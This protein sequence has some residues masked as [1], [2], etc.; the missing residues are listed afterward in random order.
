MFKHKLYFILFTVLFSGFF[1]VL[2]NKAFSQLTVT[3]GSALGLTPLGLI[4]QVL[5]GN[6]VTVSNGT[7]NG[8]AAIISSDMIGEFNA[9]GGATTQLG[10]SS[11]III[12]SGGASLA[13]GPNYSGSS[14]SASL[15]GSDPDLQSLVPYNVVFDKAVLEFDFVPIADTI[16]F[17]YVFGSEEFDEYCNSSYNDVFGFFVS[18]PG[19][20]GPFT[21][22]AI[23]IARM[24]NNPANYVTIN[25]ICN[26]GATYSWFN[27]SGVYYQYDRLTKVYT[28]W[29]LVQ[30]CQTYHL[31]IAVGDC[32]DSSFDSGVFIKANSFSAYGVTVSSSYSLPGAGDNAVEGCSDGYVTFRLS[33]P[34]SSAYTIPFTITGSAINGTDYTYIPNNIIVPA[35]QDSVRVVIHPLSDGLVEGTETVIFNVQTIVCGAGSSLSMN[36]ID[37]PPVTVNASNDT[38]ICGDPATLW[39][40]ATGG[41]PPYSYIWDNGAGNTASVVVNPAQTTT[42]SCT[43]TDLCAFSATE[44]VVIS[45][46]LTN[47]D[48][49][50]NDTICFGQTASLNATGGNSYLWSTGET[51]STISVSPSSTTTYYVTVFSTCTAMDS[52]TVVVNPLPVAVASSNPSTV[53]FGE[54]STICATGG[55][56]YFWTANPSDLTLTGQNTNACPVVSPGANTLYTVKVTDVNGCY[57]T[58]TVS[59]TVEAINPIINFSGI[60]LAGCEPLSVTFT[61]HSTQVASNARYFWE[62]G[63]GTFSYEKNPEG[64]YDAPGVYDVR[65]TITNPGNMKATVVLREYVTVYPKPTAILSTSPQNS[66]TI[67]DPVFRFYDESLGNPVQWLWDFG[68]GNIDTRQYTSHCYADRLPYYYYDFDLIQDTGTYLVTLGVITNHGCT[69]STSKYIHIEPAHD[70][71]IPNAFS[72][73]EDDKNNDFCINGFGVIEENYR[74]YIYNR[75]GELVYSTNKISGC[76]DGK[77]G[78]KPAETGIYA[79]IVEYMDVQHISHEA[80]GVIM[81]FR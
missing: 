30:P 58:D 9:T 11:G 79:Y 38:T 37:N 10:F 13:I 71:Y 6:G 72:P 31:K 39:V 61:D 42:Y 67:V 75:Q 50:P 80:K 78:G 47:A 1:I 44:S 62:F 56:S 5:V 46:G 63:N 57:D 59:L 43:I 76:W 14:G 12:T 52:V 19:I 27:T 35:G 69:D 28:S 73:N 51:S 70:L 7:F 17:Q 77:Y 81:L 15:T 20:S 25:N 33:S 54:T 60:P 66:A 49:G 21:N 26:A 41:I 16:K 64:N 22:N 29:V 68:D 32:G 2:P 40:S 3:D 24:P 4:Q 36:I 34:A 53:I 48:A 74:L 55:T 8:S 65:L 23:N 18:G 45:V